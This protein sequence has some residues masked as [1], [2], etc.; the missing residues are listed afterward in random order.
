[1]KIMAIN[2]APKEYT[3][4]LTPEMEENE[5]RILNSYAS[6]GTEVVVEYPEDYGV[7]K[8]FLEI[9]RAGGAQ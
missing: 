3:G 4:I 7:G 9:K 1:M 2:V 5:R 6:P 8:T